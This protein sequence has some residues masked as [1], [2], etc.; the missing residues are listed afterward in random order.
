MWRNVGTLSSSPSMFWKHR[1][2]PEVKL[3]PLIDSVQR[4]QIKV[5]VKLQLQSAG[6]LA[7]NLEQMCTSLGTSGKK[8]DLSPKWISILEMSVFIEA[9]TTDHDN[10]TNIQIWYFRNF[11]EKKRKIFQDGKNQSILE[12][13]T[14]L[15]GPACRWQLF[16]Y[17][18]RQKSPTRF[19]QH[20]W[21]ENYKYC[22]SEWMCGVFQE[23]IF[24]HLFPPVIPGDRTKTT[25]AAALAAD[26]RLDRSKL[27]TVWLHKFLQWPINPQLS[28]SLACC[29]PFVC[30]RMIVRALV[31]G[32]GSVGDPPPSLCTAQSEAI[33][34][35]CDVK[36]GDG[37]ACWSWSILMNPD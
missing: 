22:L 13:L 4:D 11:P 7:I 24:L 18:A 17:S 10:F 12:P 14:L 37:A 33:I 6:M 28:A 31:H 15:T 19:W 32:K 34:R 23:A 29:A 26:L 8:K 1:M 9:Y 20:E 30:V 2:I 36:H 25:L 21:T 3:R 35:S 16:D 27:R 5:S